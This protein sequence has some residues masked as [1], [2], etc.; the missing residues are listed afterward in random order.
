MKTNT[1]LKSSNHQLLISVLKFVFVSIGSLTLGAI[2]L[3]YGRWVVQQYLL[4]VDS[5]SR[6]PMT[7][8][9]IISSEV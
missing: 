5:T 7:F 3:S 4:L 8:C 6:L 1:D 9:F 2:Q